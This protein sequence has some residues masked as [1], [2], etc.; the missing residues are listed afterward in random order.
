M[1]VPSILC[2]EATQSRY[3]SEVENTFNNEAPFKMPKR[4]RC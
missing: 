4:L 3:D 2:S 1:A